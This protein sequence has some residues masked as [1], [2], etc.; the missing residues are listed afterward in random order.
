MILR[1][2]SNGGRLVVEIAWPP[3]A[4]VLVWWALRW[5]TGSLVREQLDLPVHP[6]EPSWPEHLSWDPS[7]V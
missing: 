1:S 6:R 5:I 2:Y 4:V 3:C 7:E